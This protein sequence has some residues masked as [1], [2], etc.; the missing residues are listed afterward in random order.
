[1]LL[2][3]FPVLGVVFYSRLIRK[4]LLLTLLQM[5]YLNK[6]NY[7]DDNDYHNDVFDDKKTA[8]TLLKYFSS[9]P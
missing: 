5:I 6:H 8:E 2:I 9:N 3:L 7:D 4:L 1:M